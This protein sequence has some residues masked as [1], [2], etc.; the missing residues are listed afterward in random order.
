MVVT[1]EGRSR[2]GP[3]CPE[4]GSYLC[5]F[6]P[7]CWWLSPHMPSW[8]PQPALFWGA[9]TGNTR[10]L[11]LADGDARPPRSP[12]SLLNLQLMGLLGLNGAAKRWS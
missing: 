8:G 10:H 3:F 6:H 5:H 12:Q 4:K 9:S 1:V 2:Q 11:L 7:R